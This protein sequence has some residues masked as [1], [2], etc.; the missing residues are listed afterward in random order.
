MT[1]E[2]YDWAIQKILF[3][4]VNQGSTLSHTREN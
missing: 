2:K 4:L 1:V 3:A